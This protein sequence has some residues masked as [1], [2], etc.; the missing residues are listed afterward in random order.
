VFDEQARELEAATLK[1]V[2][3]RALRFERLARRE[4]QEEPR[5]NLMKEADRLHGA[6][7]LAL[8]QAC[9][10]VL[11]RRSHQAF[12][13]FVTKLALAMTI[14]A[15]ILV[16]GVADWSQGKRDLIALRKNCAEAKKAGA[17]N[18][19]E[20][21]VPKKERAQKG[22]MQTKATKQLTSIWLNSY[23]QLKSKRSL[24]GYRVYGADA[25]RA[26]RWLTIRV[27]ET[28]RSA[29]KGLALPPQNAARCVVQVRVPAGVVV[30]KGHV[31]PHFG[32]PGVAA[33]HGPLPVTLN[34]YRGSLWG[35]KTRVGV[36]G[37]SDLQ[38]ERDFWH[39]A[40]FSE[41]VRSL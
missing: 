35:V 40:G 8:V 15:I 17:T 26:G 2:E 36:A 3:L 19:C 5:N 31:G 38:A 14:A 33:F 37:N 12:R 4:P 1:D 9:A 6:V 11:E 28:R 20:T 25:G 13:G 41:F 18:P 32:E 21:V 27:P 39:P 29:R 34:S 10:E 24:L 30:R 22:N 7:R 16:F 23:R